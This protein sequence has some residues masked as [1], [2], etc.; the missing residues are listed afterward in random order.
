MIVQLRARA[1]LLLK[2]ISLSP[3]GQDFAHL[4]LGVA[5]VGNLE[6]VVQFFQTLLLGL[7]H[8]E[9]DERK[10]HQVQPGVE[11]KRTSGCHFVKHRW[12]G[13]GENSTPEIVGCDSPGHANFTVGQRENFG[14][15]HERNGALTCVVLGLK[16]L[17]T[18]RQGLP[19]E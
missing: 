13:E 14:R 10:C 3:P 12:E 6:D 17:K 18:Y 11:S 9:K 16:R 4:V 7:G 2:D 5:S 8:K 1:A 15:V 19:G